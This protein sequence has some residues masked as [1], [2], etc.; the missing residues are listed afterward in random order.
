LNVKDVIALAQAG[1]QVGF[2]F[3]VVWW[4]LTHHDKLLQCILQHQAQE[5]EQLDRI[6][7]VLERGIT[8]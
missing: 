1:A 7:S 5:A 2:S 8:K 6:I 4:L 3:V